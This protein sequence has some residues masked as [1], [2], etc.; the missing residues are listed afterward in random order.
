MPRPRPT[1]LIAAVAMIALPSV[2]A[3]ATSQELACQSAIG[4][5]STRFVKLVHQAYRRCE[6]AHAA[7]TTCDQSQ[8][9]DLLAKGAGR[10]FD[11]LTRRCGAPLALGD[12]G[13]PGACSDPSGPPFT[14]TDLVSCID[15]SHR[16]RVIAA[17][18]TDYPGSPTPLSGEELSC[19]RAIGTA[20]ERFLVSALKA[21]QRCLDHQLGGKISPGVAC[22]AALPPSGPGTGDVKTDRRLAK[23]TTKLEAQLTNACGTVALEH[24][25]FPGACGDANGA[26]FTAADLVSCAR[27]V[28]RLGTFDMIEFEYPGGSGPALT[29]TGTTSAATP[30]PT[31]TPSPR[32]TAGI[33]DLVGI[34]SPQGDADG[35]GFSNTLELASCSNPA[36]A[37]STPLN[38][39]SLCLNETIFS[40]TLGPSW[41][42]TNKLAEPTYDLAVTALEAQ[43]ALD[44][45]VY[46][47]TTPSIGSPEACNGNWPWSGVPEHGSYALGETVEAHFPDE[48]GNGLEATIFLPPGVTCIP[49]GQPVCDGITDTVVCTAPGGATYPAVVITEGFVGTQRMYFWA[50]HRLAANGYITMTFDVSGQGR[51]QGTFPNADT[52]VAGGDQG[53]GGSGFSRDTG[54][55]FNWFVSAENPVRN[56]VA[57]DPLLI[58]NQ[59][60][61]ATSI[62]EDYVLG[63]AGHSAGATGVIAYQQ[64]T[65][66]SY[67][68]RARA[69]VAWSHFDADNTIG[70]VP[71]QMH[72]GDEDSG[73]IEPPGS[74]N[75]GPEQERRFDRLGGDRNLDG[76]PDFT[77]RD[78]Q[79]IMTAAGT[80]LD[81]SQ[82]PWAYTP[83][84]AEEVQ[85]HYSLAWFDKYLR[86]DVRRTMGNVS[87]NVIQS[88]D[89]Y[90]DYAECTSGPTCYSATARLEMSH[91]H[92]SDTWCSRYDIA[93]V[94]TDDMKGGGCQTQ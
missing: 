48:D 52:G 26:P 62:T 44:C 56:L 82:V 40:D 64:S 60:T 51:S 43:N 61:G 74:G 39:S 7:T 73:F 94:T 86:G 11:K 20:T 12:L 36:D 15:G 54:T 88:V 66:A 75:T 77:R 46:C 35:D 67:P 80:H 68:V 28:Y 1:M 22:R 34:I 21:R 19:Q 10:L 55:A 63:A 3:A 87:G 76:V 30:S 84:W 42:G 69:V 9:T 58:V 25:G 27:E 57:V 91:A 70:N 4:K 81:Y 85:L 18:G 32:P 89:P 92:L 65:E 59:G 37:S 72:S 14:A 90:N 17:V 2:A 50:A 13:F 45:G 6:D 31:T 53:G 49:H 24:L 38:D 79:I 5:E 16:P 8:R 33:G 83:T 47:Q 93:G 78:R 23:M 41:G 71:V 29:P